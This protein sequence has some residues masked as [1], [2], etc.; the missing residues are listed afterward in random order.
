MQRILFGAVLLAVAALSNSG[1]AADEEPPRWHK[2]RLRVWPGKQPVGRRDAEHTFDRAGHPDEISKLAHPSNTPRYYGYYV[3]GGSPYRGGGPG[4]ADGTWGWDY[5]GLF[6]WW[7]SRVELLWN[8][9]YQGGTGAYH[10]DGPRV[11]D[12]GPYINEL[13]KNPA[14]RHKA[15]QERRHGESESEGEHGHE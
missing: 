11:V 12:V 6:H 8:N 9:R 15:R 1:R 4:P 13:K 5:G 2:W 10:P 3:G 7:Q 14:E